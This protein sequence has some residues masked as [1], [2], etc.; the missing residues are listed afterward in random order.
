[1]LIASKT[2]ILSLPFIQ[3]LNFNFPNL[4]TLASW[5]Q[6]GKMGESSG[7]KEYLAGLL[8]GVATVI[9]G[10]PFDTVKVKLQKH[11]TEAQGI[12]YKNGLHCAA[13]ILQ[14]EGV[15]FF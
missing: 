8:A 10:H 13:R 14:A 1:M 7:Y 3:N 6:A 12:K 11:N 2:S 5:R 15:C 4:K 9:T